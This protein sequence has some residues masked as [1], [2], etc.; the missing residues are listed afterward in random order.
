VR[1]FINAGFC[2]P[3]HPEIAARCQSIANGIRTG[4]A[5]GDEHAMVAALVADTRLYFDEAV[6]VV[7]GWDWRDGGRL[8][9]KRNAD[10]EPLKTHLG[11][12][13]Q[14]LITEWGTSGGDLSKL[15]IE[16]GNELDGSYWKNHLDAFHRMALT[17]Y[18]RVRAISD[19]VRF[20]TGSTMNFNKEF[21]WKRGGYE[22]LDELCGLS[23]PMDTVQGLH[24]YRG[25]GRYWPSF[26]SDESALAA[27]TKVLRGRQV[28]IT[29]MGWASGIG[30]SDELIAEMAREEMAMWRRFGAVCYVGYQAQDHAKPGNVG[31]GGFGAFS[32][33]VDG[34]EEKPWAAAVKEARA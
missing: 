1:I 28:A 7:G 15:W 2:E 32:N 31:E 33:V 22:V 20:I 9:Q 34:L 5:I 6:F 30:D 25:G 10:L 3:L 11:K 14:S 26:D 23:W 4:L 13:C 16:I 29:E 27:L 24:P 8:V 19:Q 12:Q 21:S 18:E 17:C